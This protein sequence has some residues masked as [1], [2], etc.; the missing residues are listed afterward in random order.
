MPRFSCPRC[1]R[2]LSLRPTDV[3]EGGRCPCGA[4]YV[5]AMTRANDDRS[6]DG[7][8][9][10]EGSAVSTWTVDDDGSAVEVHFFA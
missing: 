4:R 7:P 8:E 1:G 6:A 2:L 9:D 5:V 3:E 10:L